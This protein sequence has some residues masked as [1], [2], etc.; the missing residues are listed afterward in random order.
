MF[1]IEQGIIKEITSKTK[2]KTIIKVEINN[3]I[4][5]AVNYNELTGDCNIDDT[6][7][8]NTTAVNLNLG[9]GGYHFVIYNL[10]NQGLKSKV[11]GHIMKL[12]YSPYQIKVMAAEEQYSP[13]HTRFN[14]FE[15]LNNMPVIVGSLHS[16]LIPVVATLKY[17]SNKIRIAYIM[18]DGASLP[19]WF[20]DTVELLKG[21]KLIDKTI[22][23]G[24]AFGGDIETVNI[25]NGLIAAKEI[26]NC[27]IAIVT[28]GPGI[29]GTG[30]R[31][32]F[33]GIE[34]GYIIDAVNS[35][36]GCAIGIPRIGFG[37]KRFRHKGISHHSITVFREITKSK[38]FIPIFKLDDQKHKLVEAQLRNFDLYEK[39]NIIVEKENVLEKALNHF[40]LSVDT[41]GRNYYDDSSYFLTCSAAGTFGYKK[42]IE[43][44]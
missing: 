25:Y 40:N 28:M 32:G 17:L 23:I 5:L 1:D 20:S 29:V 9:T 2:E 12:R 24:H 11:E 30:T 15:S 21:L 41:M 36:G 19:I 18:T 4:S 43:V 35:L 10:N 8:L 27:D 13:Y 34:Q 38:T 7:I 39:H 26:V 16:M 42:N 44:N 33:T 6:V 22:T 3:Q 14:T 31:Y 37:D